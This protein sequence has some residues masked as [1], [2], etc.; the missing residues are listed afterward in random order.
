M[1]TGDR[2]GDWLYRALF[3]AGLANQ[4][5]STD[6]RDGLV[7]HNCAVTNACHCAPPDNRPTTEELD[8]C[9]RFFDRTVDVTQPLV[10]L[11]LGSIAW[12]ACIQLFRR[13]GW[14]EGRVPKFG[15]GAE[16]FAADRA[17]VGCYHPSQ[18]NTFTGRLTESMLDTVVGRAARLAAAPT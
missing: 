2:S 17:M 16:L 5:R 9:A 10:F 18:Q 11:A 12:R 4:Q 14:Y 1:F 6:A 15:H 3:R 8:Q 7:L 13:Q